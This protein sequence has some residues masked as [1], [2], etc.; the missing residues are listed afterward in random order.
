MKIVSLLWVR[1]ASR[2][3]ALVIA[4]GAIRPLSNFEFQGAEGKRGSSVK[5]KNVK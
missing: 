1:N 5:L 2:G 3:A 4:L